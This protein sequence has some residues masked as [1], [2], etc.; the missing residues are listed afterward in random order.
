MASQMLQSFL[1]NYARKYMKSLLGIEVSQILSQHPGDRSSYEISPEK[2]PDGEDLQ[3]NKEKLSFAVKKLLNKIFVSADNVPLEVRMVLFDVQQNI[4]EKFPE[5]SHL[6]LAELIFTRFFCEALYDPMENRLIQ[7]NPTKSAQAALN[8]I[9]EILEK[10]AKNDP[11]L[12]PDKLWINELIT[13]FRG[14]VLEYF[15]NVLI[16]PDQEM[17]PIF[18]SANISEKVLIRIYRVLKTIRQKIGGNV[19]GVSTRS[20]N[21]SFMNDFHELMNTCQQIE[22]RL[23]KSSKSRVSISKFEF[24]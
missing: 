12:E 18:D 20:Q 14:K 22:E 10:I 8:L 6:I 11:F 13:N 3:H 5:F 2:L 7:A 1:R 4:A 16:F 21:V 9:G 15:Q 19:V 17:I 23:M 24:K